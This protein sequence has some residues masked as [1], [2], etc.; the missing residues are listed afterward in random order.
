M[1]LQTSN[2]ELARHAF[3]TWAATGTGVFDI[4]ADNVR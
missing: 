3:K 1:T 4:L 2:K